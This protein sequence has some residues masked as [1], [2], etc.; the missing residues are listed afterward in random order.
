MAYDDILKKI[1]K[2]PNYPENL[3]FKEETNKTQIYLHHTVSPSYSI[4]G[5]IATWKKL[6]SH[7]GTC[8]ILTADGLAH[9][10]FSSKYWANHLGLDNSSFLPFH[11]PYKNLNVNSIGIEIDNAGGLVQQPNGTWKSSFGSI[12][13]PE[14]VTVFEKPYRGYYGFEKYTDE[15]IQTVKELLLYWGKI[16][17]IN[18]EYDE[19]MWDICENA[20]NSVSGIYSHSSV[21][22]SKSDIFPQLSMIE[23]LKT[24]KEE[25]EKL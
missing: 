21:K 19:T 25:S 9:Q 24:L 4:D 18:L 12:I 17:N 23:M 13:K 11:L 3:F 20:L 16:W 10:L 15:Q 8:I 14:N 1:V 7:V 6:T 2:V 22:K 5:D